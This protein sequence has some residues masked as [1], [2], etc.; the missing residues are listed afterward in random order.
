[1]RIEA[2]PVWTNTGTRQATFSDI[3][4]GSSGE[5]FD[6]LEPAVRVSAH[7][8]ADQ[9]RRGARP[10]RLTRS[11]DSVRHNS[12]RVSAMPTKARSRG[13]FDPHSI[14]I[15]PLH[16]PATVAKAAAPA[17]QLTYRQGP[18]IPTVEVFT[19]FWGNL[20]KKA[21]RAAIVGKVNSFF[22][23]VLTSPLIDQL[24]EYSVGPYRIAHGRHTGNS[25][26]HHRIARRVGPPFSVANTT[27]HLPS[28]EPD[29]SFITLNRHPTWLLRLPLSTRL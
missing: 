7:F 14:R 24:S 29:D 22:E 6:P 5:A 28:E 20:W 21:P 4:H 15:V 9:L 26:D 23:F 8:K 10:V 25:D 12:R 19:I 17:A 3:L 18:L 13:T 16:V 11:C 27:F 2:K 1:M